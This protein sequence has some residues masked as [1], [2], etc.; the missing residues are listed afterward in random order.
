VR[1]YMA[2]K[3]P[4]QGLLEELVK[5]YLQGDGQ[6]GELLL[7]KPAHRQKLEIL[8]RKHTT[9]TSVPWEE[10]AQQAHL[11]VLQA[12]RS[13]SFRLGGAREFY[14]WAARVAEN[15]IIDS[16]RRE[17]RKL[18]GR[19]LVSLDRHLPET[20]MTLGETIADDFDLWD[21]VERGDLILKAREAIETIDRRYPK[22]GYLALWRG[23]VQEKDVSQIAA[24]LGVKQPEIS[25][26]WRELSSRIAG[27][28]GLLSLEQVEREVRAIRQGSGKGRK[29]SDTQW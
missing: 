15:A 1:L 6:A 27:E 20:D 28:L 11:K 10:A 23:L 12:A 21:A 7:T 16:V 4:P 25:K 2:P 29:R 19:R 8:A 22:K 26:R 17:K 13:G 9:G 18:G 24:A 14:S 5:R 3:E